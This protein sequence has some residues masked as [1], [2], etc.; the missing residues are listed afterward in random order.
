MNELFLSVVI[1]AYN[2]EDRIEKTLRRVDAYL[3]SQTY[4]YEIIVVNDGSKDSTAEKVRQAFSQLPH[5]RLIDNKEN[6][7]KGWVVKQ[8]MLEAKGQIRLFMDADNSTAI[9]QVERML[10]YFSA[11]GG[12]PEGG[13]EAY[14]VVFGS[15]RAKGA[16][17]AIHQAWWRENLGRVFN[18]LMRLIAWLPYSDTQAG[19]KAFTSEAA[20]A[21]FSR[22]TIWRWAFD[23]EVLVI[24]RAL[25][26]KIKEV[27]ITW[28]NDPKSHVK[29]SGMVKMLFEVIKI[30]LGSLSGAYK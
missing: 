2:E 5:L 24:A 18:L 3:K 6:H 16:V 27:P 26:F 29:F 21:I 14:D 4:S 7:G 28:V 13:R 20:E 30:R 25:G 1:P 10:P 12:S 17:I 8:G 15:R 9:D 19:F 11:Y 23:V 22:Q